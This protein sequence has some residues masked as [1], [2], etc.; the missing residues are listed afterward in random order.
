M[1][2]DALDFMLFV[3]GAAA[4]FAAPIAALAA[5][6]LGLDFLSDDA[7]LRLAISASLAAG[8]LSALALWFVVRSP[9]SRPTSQVTQ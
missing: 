9:Q 2:A 4:G 3:G 8:P 7:D 1:T 5:L 6:V